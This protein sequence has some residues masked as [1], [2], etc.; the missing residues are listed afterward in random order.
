MSLSQA[1]LE[2]Q[3]FPQ[4]NQEK[5]GCHPGQ[6][7][8]QRSTMTQ[9]KFITTPQLVEVFP[10]GKSQ[11]QALRDS[12][13]FQEGVHW[14]KYPG[15][16]AQ[17]VLWNWPLIEDY[18]ATGG[19]EAHQRVVEAYLASLPSNQTRTRKGGLKAA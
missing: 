18:L 15:S 14:V 3:V 4:P 7:N 19:G 11:L 2:F 17:R 10:L 8:K 5:T 16:N 9:T 6:V 12:G 13:T 1:L